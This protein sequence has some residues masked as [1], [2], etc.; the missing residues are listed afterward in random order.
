MS[1]ERLQLPHW[2]PTVLAL[3]TT[4]GGGHSAAPYDS[5]NLAA[6]VGDDAAAVRANRS[7]LAQ[8]LPPG[9]SI[10]WLRQVHGSAVVVAGE[11]PQPEADASWSAASG[12]ACAVLTADCLPVLFCARDGSAVAAAHAGWRG[13]AAGVLEAT[14][15]ALPVPAPEVL[16]WLG[17]AIGAA[18]YEVGPQL[19]AVFFAD[20]GAAA[21]DCFAPGAGDRYLADLPA[22]A[23]LRLRRAGVTAIAQSRRCTHDDP[24]RYFSYRRDGR[25]G[26]MATLVTRLSDAATP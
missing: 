20:L 5:F 23:T 12:V 25:T 17:P 14:L 11:R 6:H 15:A 2:P 1:I 10:Q 26:R 7:R 21:A 13:L 9:T 24:A 8:A 3:S 4:R 16:A 18:A 19:R 22:L